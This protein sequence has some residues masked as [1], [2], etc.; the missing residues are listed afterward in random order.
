MW[1]NMKLALFSDSRPVCYSNMKPDGFIG[2]KTCCNLDQN[3]MIFNCGVSFNGEP[4]RL[5][6]S[7]S[8][9]SKP[10]N[11]STSCEDQPNR[12]KCS[13]TLKPD[14]SY[15]GSIFICQIASQNGIGY[16][17][18]TEVIKVLCK[19]IGSTISAK[20]VRESDA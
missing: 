3:Y 9:D 11:S 6:W 5:T 14:P 19:L 18:S 2:S 15:D 12:K 7:S 13:I 16:K 17:C 10:L 4:P 20:N 1:P 8:N